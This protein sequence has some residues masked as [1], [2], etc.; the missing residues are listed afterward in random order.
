MFEKKPLPDWFTPPGKD[1][2]PIHD[3]ECRICGAKYTVNINRKNDTGPVAFGLC[4]ACY[5]SEKYK[6]HL[7]MILTSIVFVGLVFVLIWYICISISVDQY[8]F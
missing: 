7:K 4:S 1:L 2:N 5:I 3:E 8:V 6:Y